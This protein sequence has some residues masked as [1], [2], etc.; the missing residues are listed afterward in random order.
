MDLKIAVSGCIVIGSG[1]LTISYQGQGDTMATR[2]ATG[3]W[4]AI[5]VGGGFIAGGGRRVV[6]ALVVGKGGRNRGKWGRK[7]WVR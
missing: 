3:G 7:L 2:G 4:R 5:V 6:N 1:A